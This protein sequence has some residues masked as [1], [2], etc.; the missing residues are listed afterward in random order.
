MDRR[1]KKEDKTAEKAIKKGRG[2]EEEL[3]YKINTTAL[4]ATYTEAKQIAER[5]E[6]EDRTEGGIGREKE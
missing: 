3:S 2:V 5:T 6:G 4:I 1:K